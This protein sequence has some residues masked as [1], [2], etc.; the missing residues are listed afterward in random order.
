MM[1]FLE[2]RHDAA[3][4]WFQRAGEYR[5]V[6][7]LANAARAA[8]FYVEWQDKKRYDK[9]RPSIAKW[10]QKCRE[11]LAKVDLHVLDVTLA[12]QFEEVEREVGRIE[13]TSKTAERK[14]EGK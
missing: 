11:A 7:A 10:V 5:P 6:A 2:W 13:E 9:Y 4:T 3:A 14:E 12:R 1:E 8:T